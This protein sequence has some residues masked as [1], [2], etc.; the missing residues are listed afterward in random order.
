MA[1]FDYRQRSRASATFLLEVR[2]LP[3]SAAEGS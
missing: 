1:D 3:P 2:R